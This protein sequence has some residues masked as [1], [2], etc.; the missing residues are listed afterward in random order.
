MAIT[1][2][3]NALAEAYRDG[4]DRGLVLAVERI[5]AAL[6]LLGYD[7]QRE[8]LA[9]IATGQLTVEQLAARLREQNA[10]KPTSG[11]VH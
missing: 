8:I 9:Q 10:G 11:S 3:S 4:V 6:C 5:A 2:D 7:D 1:V